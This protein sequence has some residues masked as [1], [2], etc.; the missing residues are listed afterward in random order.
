MWSSFSLR[1]RLQPAGAAH[2]RV[3]AGVGEGGGRVPLGRRGG[4]DGELA[5][6]GAAAR[7]A[8]RGVVG[9]DREVPRADLGRELPD[10]ANRR[11]AGRR[12][13]PV[14]PHR[15]AVEPGCPPV[16]L[17]HRLVGEPGEVADEVEVVVDRRVDH[18]LGPGRGRLEEPG[19]L[20]DV[21]AE[22]QDVVVLVGDGDPHQ[23]E[24]DAR[25][26]V[27]VVVDDE[28]AGP[29]AAALAEIGGRIAEQVATEID[30]VDIDLALPTPTAA[31]AGVAVGLRV[32]PAEHP[33]LDR[34]GLGS[35]EQDL[36]G[37]VGQP[38]G[39]GVGRV[40]RVFGRGPPVHADMG[41]AYRRSVG[42][43]PEVVAELVVGLA[44]AGEDRAGLAAVGSLEPR[45][46]ERQL[47][48]HGGRLTG[49][50]RRGLGPRGEE[51]GRL[52]EDPL[53]PLRL[54]GRG[55]CRGQG[56]EREQ[57]EEEA[58]SALQEGGS[59]RIRNLAVLLKP[60]AR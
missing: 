44:R 10:P 49:L 24:R 33:V 20:G 51:R 43:G 40:R 55:E 56:G 22:L 14:V 28:V 26:A 35:G 54:P 59:R 15:R 47:T 42:L 53:R 11:R 2:L 8:D 34:V 29:P 52:R 36:L 48:Q 46:H 41:I 60:A 27:V 50:G 13:Q 7:F 12:R 23:V 4:E 25:E 16:G 17:G 21:V 18:L 3:A 30:E 32:A 31:G 45:Q 37:E 58:E 39:V 38:V 57:G 1:G 5:A 19:V 9:G 6:E